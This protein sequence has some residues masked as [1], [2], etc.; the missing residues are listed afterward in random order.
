VPVPTLV[1]KRGRPKKVVPDD[2]KGDQ[3]SMST[4][5]SAKKRGRPK[6]GVDQ[7]DDDE[8]EDEEALA[9]KTRVI[10]SRDWRASGLVVCSKECRR[11]GR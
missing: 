8:D 2:E 3:V 7:D 9:E 1:K 4:P 5:V 10:K 6:K 11:R